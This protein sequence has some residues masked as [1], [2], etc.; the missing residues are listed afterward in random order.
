MFKLANAD[1]FAET[2][3]NSQRGHDASQDASGRWARRPG[4][5]DRDANCVLPSTQTDQDGLFA[6]TGCVGPRKMPLNILNLGP[7]IKGSISHDN[8]IFSSPERPCCYQYASITLPFPEYQFSKSLL[9]YFK[10]ERI[11]RLI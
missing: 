8:L 11:V 7:K 5:P 10:K 4:A 3:Q 1:Q 9:Y 6:S 2:D